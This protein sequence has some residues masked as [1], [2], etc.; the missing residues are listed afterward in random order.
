MS[1]STVTGF[2]P[3]RRVRIT[4]VNTV[5]ASR[6][7]VIVDEKDVLTIV[8]SLGNVV[9]LTAKHDSPDSRHATILRDDE[10]NVK[11]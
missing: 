3:W 9:R 2:F 5:E 11:K 7:A 10:R 4:Y 1:K 6:T 8:T